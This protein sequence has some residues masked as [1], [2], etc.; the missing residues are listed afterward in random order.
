MEIG[1]DISS[2]TS[3]IQGLIGP[4]I[5]VGLIALAGFIGRLVFVSFGSSIKE[6]NPLRNFSGLGLIAT[7]IA[8]FVGALV[9]T[10]KLDKAV[11]LIQR[12]TMDPFNIYVLQRDSCDLSGSK[13]CVIVFEGGREISVNWFDSKV[14]M[15]E[16]L[17][18]QTGA[19]YK[20]LRP[21]SRVGD[22]E[23]IGVG[24]S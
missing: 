15:W 11:H 22:G 2:L 6:A 23:S 4:G 18:P 8:M 5:I 14:Y 3:G 21:R 13:Y 1:I 12:N 19:V 16:L 10:G 20:T 17:N 7:S 9:V 24:L